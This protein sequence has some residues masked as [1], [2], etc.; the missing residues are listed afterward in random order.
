M[1]EEIG[2]LKIE[3]CI[4]LYQSK[5]SKHI[6][7][8]ST[9]IL[10]SDWFIST[11]NM[12]A[13]EFI[14]EMEVWLKVSQQC[15]FTYLFDRCINFLYIISPDE[16]L[17]MANL[18]NRAWVEMGLKKYAHIVPAEFI[19]SLSVEQVFGEYLDMKLPNQYPII[20]FVDEEDAITWLKS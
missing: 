19:S 13:E 10:Y 17:W 6:Y 4:V 8:S 7:Q 14:Q 20:D 9:E 12:Q 11:E 16:Q 15:K 3:N 2:K 1:I 18:L 5:Y